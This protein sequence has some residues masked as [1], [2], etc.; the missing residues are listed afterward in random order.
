MNTSK[1]NLSYFRLRKLIGA[2]GMLLPFVLWIGAWQLLPSISDYYYHYMGIAFITILMWCG[3]FLMAYKGEVKS[4]WFTDN[5]ITTIGG[6][7]IMLTAIFPTPF[8]GSDVSCP[9]PICYFNVDWPGYIHF[10]SASLFFGLMGALAYYNFTKL[11]SDNQE[12][13]PGKIK[14]NAFYRFCAWGMW[15]TL[16]LTL[17]GYLMKEYSVEYGHYFQYSVFFGELVMLQFF[18]L[19][20]LVK[21]KALYD[22]GWQMEDS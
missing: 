19:A 9:T 16:V 2:S 10:G 12:P 1:T 21:G 15:I 14:R 17:C 4:S 7:L 8:D 20:W 18:G 11:E 22:I 13:S 3:A 6:I 5:G